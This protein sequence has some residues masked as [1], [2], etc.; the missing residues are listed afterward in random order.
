MATRLSKS[1]NKTALRLVELFGKDGY[2]IRR[3]ERGE[4]DPDKPTRVPD[5]VVR[6]YPCKAAVT[7]YEDK[8]IDGIQVMRNDMQVVVAW[9]EDLPTDIRS[10]DMFVDSNEDPDE[11]IVYK[12][13]PN[14]QPLKV[15][16]VLVAYILQVRR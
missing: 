8:Q 12:I 13:V 3:E 4:V 5:M 1:F 9:T 10:G 7:T 16:G 14:G 11:E 2:Y 15:N 6:N